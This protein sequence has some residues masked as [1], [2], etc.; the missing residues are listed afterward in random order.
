M[1]IAEEDIAKIRE[2]R[3]KG[4]CYREILKGIHSP[5]VRSRLEERVEKLEQRT[6]KIDRFKNKLESWINR[7][8]SEFS[9]QCGYVEDGYCTR[10]G[11]NKNPSIRGAKKIGKGWH[12]KKDP[13]FC[14]FCTIRRQR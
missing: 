7:F 14:V 1:G 2:L 12:E 11:W 6:N 9:E 4:L 8:G 3:S 13:M 10:W 5:E